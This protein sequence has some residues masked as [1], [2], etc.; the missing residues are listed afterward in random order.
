MLKDR[1][2]P[3]GLTDTLIG[4]GSSIEG[5][6]ECKSNLRLEGKFSGEIECLGQIVIGETGEAHSNIQGGEVIVA[7]KVVGDILT[8]GKLTITS[9]GQ[10]EGNVDVAKLIILEGGQLNGSSK[11]E[12]TAPAPIPAPAPAP[13]S[14]KEKRKNSAEPEAG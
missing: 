8:G 4:Q 12:L 9:N 1:K 6:L 3:A 14:A 2:N 7:G 11:M 13:M 10:V 5:K